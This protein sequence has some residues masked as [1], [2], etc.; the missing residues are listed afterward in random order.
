MAG[1][2]RRTAS[3][4]ERLAWLQGEPLAAHIKVRV[5]AVRGLSESD[6]TRAAVLESMNAG[7]TEERDGI[8]IEVEDQVRA[9]LRASSCCLVLA[10]ACLLAR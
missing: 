9:S 7:S 10:V 8:A 3:H 2:S 5:V 6:A 1:E 4:E